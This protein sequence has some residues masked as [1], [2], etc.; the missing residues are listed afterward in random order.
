[1]IQERSGSPD[2]LVYG[3]SLQHLGHVFHKQNWY[4]N[5][6]TQ[7]ERAMPL[8]RDSVGQDDAEY[9]LLLRD[10][11]EVYADQKNFSDAERTLA[12]SISILERELGAKDLTVLETRARYETVRRALDSIPA[13]GI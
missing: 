1:M 5:A 12:E 6:Q 7:Y 3:R 9:G 4:G 2:P 8:L 11:G 10:L 13:S